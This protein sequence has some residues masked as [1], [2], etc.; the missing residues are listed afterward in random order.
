[1]CGCSLRPII[2]AQILIY[3]VSD[4]TLSQRSMSEITNEPPLNK[5]DHAWAYGLYLP[6]GVE[7]TDPDIS[8]LFA[9]DLAG[10]P[11]ALI[12]TAGNDPLR[13]EGES[14]A[15]ALHAEGV[16]VRSVDCPA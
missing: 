7:R 9:T 6:D 4:A 8:P 2:A 11:P 13:D 5:G 1:M 10:L 3:P 12:S 16:A 14:Y 15:K